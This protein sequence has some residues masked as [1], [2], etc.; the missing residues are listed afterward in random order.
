M[1]EGDYIGLDIGTVRSGI[2]RAG[3]QA[4]LAEPLKI[5]PTTQLMSVLGDL[6]KDK[7]ISAVVVGLPRNLEGNDTR[8]TEWVRQWVTAAKKQ[9]PLRYIFQ[10]EAL[11]SV[12]A[13]TR[14]PENAHHDALAAAII[15]QDY[16]DGQKKD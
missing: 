4:R 13:Q 7:K 11:T 10:D 1:A 12:A 3:S 5:V 8:Q 14:Q 6:T 15:L 9:L 2:A 16:L